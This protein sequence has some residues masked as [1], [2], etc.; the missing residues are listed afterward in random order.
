MAF[1]WIVTESSNLADGKGDVGASVGR[2]VEEH[3]NNPAVA[4][5]FGHGRSIMVDSESSL[6]SSGSPVVIAVGH[7]AG[8]FLNFLNQ[9]F[10]SESQRCE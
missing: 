1:L 10:L 2:Q 6:L 8:G 5:S 3:A 7:D 9:T 4:P